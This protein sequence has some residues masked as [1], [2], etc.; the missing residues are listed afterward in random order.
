[1]ILVFYNNIVLIMEIPDLDFK[2]PATLQPM[3]DVV[4]FY[5]LEAS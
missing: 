5:S 2:T 4:D 1:M 3:M